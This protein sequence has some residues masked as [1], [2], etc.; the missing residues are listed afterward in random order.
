M[1]A[2]N[3][4]RSRHNRIRKARTAMRKKMREYRASLAPVKKTATA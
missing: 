1:S 2:R 3:G 4:D